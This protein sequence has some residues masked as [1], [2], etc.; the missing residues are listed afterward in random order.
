MIKKSNRNSSIELLRILS[1]FAIVIPHY[2]YHS[3][4]NWGVYNTLFEG[5]LK[6]NLFLHFF[7]KL[8]VDIF[9]IIG[10]YFSFCVKRN[11]T[12]KDQS[13]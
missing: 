7:G 3:T 8:G 4:F 12:L 11:L 9:V 10:A 13:I 1:M 2:A 6:V 5:A